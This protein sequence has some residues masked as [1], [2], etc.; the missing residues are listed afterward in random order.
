MDVPIW[1]LRQ[2]FRPRFMRFPRLVRAEDCPGCHKKAD[3]AQVS[4]MGKWWHNVCW[5]KHLKT[6]PTVAAIITPVKWEGNRVVPRLP[7]EVL[8]VSGNLNNEEYRFWIGSPN[9]ISGVAQCRACRKVCH[10]AFE[11][12][13]HKDDKTCHV[14][15]ETCNRRLVNA[16]GMLL[17][18]HKCVVCREQT[19]QSIYG[20]PICQKN[21]IERW[22]YSNIEW[23]ALS[24]A[25]LAQLVIG[26]AVE[27]DD[28]P[29]GVVEA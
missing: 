24:Q 22:R 12:I 5:I 19:Y 25:L 11:R 20:V 27:P 1:L 8:G 21:C 7:G 29:E 16:Y 6:D 17:A 26:G 15:G 13:A 4:K 23:P 10:D 28:R 18:Q 9:R 3:G 14:G 2:Q